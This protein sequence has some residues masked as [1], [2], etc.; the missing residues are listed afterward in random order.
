MEKKEANLNFK[1]EPSFKRRL[2]A[3]AEV[4]DRP[5]T[6]IVKEAINDKFRA[7]AEMNPDV[8]DALKKA[9]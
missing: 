7:L 9:A 4:L 2:D 3:V 1:V 8:A 6:R 5:V